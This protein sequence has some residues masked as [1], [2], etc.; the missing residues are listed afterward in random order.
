MGLI[1]EF[2]FDGF[3]AGFALV[4]QEQIWSPEYQMVVSIGYDD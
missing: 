3:I 2:W 1:E 4:C